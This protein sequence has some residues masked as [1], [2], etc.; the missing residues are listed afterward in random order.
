[1]TQQEFAQWVKY[2]GTVVPSFGDWLRKLPPFERDDMLAAWYGATLGSIELDDAKEGS[3]RMLRVKRPFH[4]DEQVSEV[5]RLAIE[6]AQERVA[7]PPSNGW[8]PQWTEDGERV[9]RCRYCLDTRG[10]WVRTVH[11]DLVR[12]FEQTYEEPPFPSNWRR[13]WARAAPRPR[14]DGTLL[15]SCRHP[16]VTTVHYRDGSSVAVF[17]P[18]RDCQWSYPVE[19]AVAKFVRSRPLVFAEGYF[20]EQ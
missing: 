18:Q 3:R 15:C 7:T 4:F 12:W 20:D 16:G 5:C 2:H 8:G 11:P 19:D 17:D 14:Q 1:M 9:Y 10:N 6:A 13:E